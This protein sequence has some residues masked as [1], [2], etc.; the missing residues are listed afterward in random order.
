MKP[1]SILAGWS[2]ASTAVQVRVIHAKGGDTLEVWRSDGS[3]RLALAN[4]LALGGDYV[5][6]GAAIFNGTMEQ[7]G[8]A[9]TLTLGSKVSGSVNSAAVTGKTVTWTPD[10]NATDDAGNKVTNKSVSATGPAF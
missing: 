6:S 7:G 2:G 3:G 8:A 4:P 1:S 10:T 5:P 9:I